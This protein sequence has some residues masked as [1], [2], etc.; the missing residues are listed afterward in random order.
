LSIELHGTGI[1]LDS[2]LTSHTGSVQ[3]V[4]EDLS[5]AGTDIDDLPAPT[6]FLTTSTPDSLDIP[7][8]KHMVALLPP[9]LSE[10][11]IKHMESFV[12][13]LDFQLLRVWFI[14]WIVRDRNRRSRHGR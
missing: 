1:D 2:F 14:G 4:L 12:V 3:Q 6:R 8:G 10:A 5:H 7:L 11:F 13:T 9:G